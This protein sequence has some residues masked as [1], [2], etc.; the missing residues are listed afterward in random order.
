MTPAPPDIRITNNTRHKEV[1]ARHAVRE[2]E[3]EG[4]LFVGVDYKEILSPE[5]FAVFAKLRD[6]WGRKELKKKVYRFI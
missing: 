5:D 2:V 1:E 4:L 6:L 3:E